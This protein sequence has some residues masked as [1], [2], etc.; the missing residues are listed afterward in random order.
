MPETAFSKF[1]L[2]P[3]VLLLYTFT[4]AIVLTD[5]LSSLLE[6]ESS[7]AF[8]ANSKPITIA[9]VQVALQGSARHLQD[10]LAQV[11]ERGHTLAAWA[12]AAF[13]RRSAGCAAKPGTLCIRIGELKQVV[14]REQCG[15]RVP[16]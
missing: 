4:R 12:E 13:A 3:L 16:Q 2:L 1:L 11:A 7:S 14:E 8:N 5:Q 10:E 6:V 9:T 15:A